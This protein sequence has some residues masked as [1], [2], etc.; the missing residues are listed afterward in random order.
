M[1]GAAMLSG[2]ER[3]RFSPLRALLVSLALSWAGANTAA[4][5]PAANSLSD[6]LREGNIETSALTR[7]GAKIH[8]GKATAVVDAPFD[9]V[10]QVVQN[11]GDYAEFLPHFHVSR[12]LA[13]RGGNAIAYME[14]LVLKKTYT[15]WVELRFREKRAQ[16][17][18]KVI[19]GTMTRGNV[20]EL[21]LR[22]EVAPL[23]DGKTLVTF[24][25]LVD[26]DLPIPSFI[27]SDQNVNSA[28]RA[29]R[30]LRKRVY[31]VMGRST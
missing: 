14:V 23:A 21:S 30:E 7:Q 8:W 25:L 6:S 18:T 26:P 28:M 31:K 4:A 20:A 12:V 10:L 2:L 15:I 17:Q 16:G 24:A 13:Q 5:Q 27:L 22:W 29:V 11:Y 3:M 1:K 9:Q 19:E